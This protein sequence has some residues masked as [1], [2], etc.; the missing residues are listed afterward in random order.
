MD[1]HNMS[2]GL[3]DA[4]KR[5]MHVEKL[6]THALAAV[7]EQMLAE[8]DMIIDALNSHELQLGFVCEVDTAPKDVGIF[9]QS[10]ATSCCRLTATEGGNRRDTSRS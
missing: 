1:Q 6:R 9:E 7:P 2:M 4:I 3:G 5:L 8:R 10:A